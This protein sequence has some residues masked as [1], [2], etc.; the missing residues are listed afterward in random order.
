MCHY[1]CG[2]YCLQS[3]PVCDVE[4]TF[5]DIKSTNITLGGSDLNITVNSISVMAD[6]LYPNRDYNATCDSS[7]VRGSNTS[8]IMLREYTVYICSRLCG[9]LSEINFLIIYFQ[10]FL[11]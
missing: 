4:L 2:S 1:C 5:R 11:S 3:A 10:P 6:Q 9:L 7:N 8:R